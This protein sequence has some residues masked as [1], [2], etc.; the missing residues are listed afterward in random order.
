MTART[1]T[2]RTANRATSR[3]VAAELAYYSRA[4]KAPSLLDAAGRLA[5]R[6]TAECGGL[7]WCRGSSR[8]AT[9][10]SRTRACC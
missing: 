8:T 3:D 4:L 6:A 5:E 2:Q 9:G 10:P 7:W 1:N